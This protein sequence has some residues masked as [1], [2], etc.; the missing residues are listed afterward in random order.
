MFMKYNALKHTGEVITAAIAKMIGPGRDRS[1][2]HAR[3]ANPTFD[4]VEA[5]KSGA[6][7]I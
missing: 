5:P 7:S 4:P 6:R 3:Q 2:G 1:R